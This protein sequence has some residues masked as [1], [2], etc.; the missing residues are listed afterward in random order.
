MAGLRAEFSGI[1]TFS[2]N[3]SHKKSGLP[4]SIVTKLFVIIIMARYR[5][6]KQNADD[7]IIIVT[8]ACPRLADS[9][10][11]HLPRDDCL[12]LHMDITQH[13]DAITIMISSSILS[14]VWIKDQCD[15]EGITNINSTCFV[16][17]YVRVIVVA[18]VRA[19]VLIL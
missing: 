3:S 19:W 17:K 6:K 10:F 2:N 4:C 11:S 5:L 16:R 15:G 12:S 8:A 1:E 9:V 13:V 18:I 7:S 14:R